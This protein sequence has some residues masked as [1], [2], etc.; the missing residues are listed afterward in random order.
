MPTGA[1]RTCHHCVPVALHTANTL[2]AFPEMAFEL[3][4]EPKVIAAS[5][6]LLVI[7]QVVYRRNR[8]TGRPPVVPYVVPWVGSAITLGKNSDAFFKHAMYV[9]QLFT[10]L[11]VG[12]K[13]PNFSARYGDIFTIKTF[14][15]TITYVTSPQV[16][17]TGTLINCFG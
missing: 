11:E 6:L 9:K 2:L 7:A 1:R 16:K 17:E 10:H 15:R 4:K 12:N 8:I 13:L 14:G 5:V 3:W